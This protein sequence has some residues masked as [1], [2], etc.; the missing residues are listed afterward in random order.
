[1]KVFPT[2]SGRKKRKVVDFP[3]TGSHWFR[4]SFIELSSLSPLSS[5]LW[6]SLSKCSDFCTLLSFAIYLVHHFCGQRK[7][8]RENERK[9]KNCWVLQ[10]IVGREK[11]ELCLL[12]LQKNIE[13]KILKIENLSRKKRERKQVTISIMDSNRL[14]LIWWFHFS[15]EPTFPYDSWAQFHQRSMYSFNACRYRMCN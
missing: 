4:N 15:L 2:L 12:Q 13:Q 6:H 7:E 3:L 8:E 1:M 10:S 11:M 9:K 14:Y 5:F